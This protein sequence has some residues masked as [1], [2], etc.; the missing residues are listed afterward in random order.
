MSAV[1]SDFTGLD[2][3]IS[4]EYTSKGTEPASFL[5]GF[6]LSKDLNFVDGL[7]FNSSL[8]IGD[9]A[10]VFVVPGET[11]LSIEGGFSLET[12]FGII[13]GPNESEELVLIGSACEGNGL[14]NC[15]PFDPFSFYIEW[16]VGNEETVRN[17]T[18][19]TAEG[20][21][22]ATQELQRVLDNSSLSGNVT[23]TSVGSSSIVLNFDAS[24]SK[25]VLLVEKDC[26][27][28]SDSSLNPTVVKQGEFR[29]PEGTKPAPS[30]SPTNEY[31]FKD[32]EAKKRGYQFVVGSTKIT[33]DIGIEGSAEVGANVGEVIEIGAEID[34]DFGGNLVFSA[35]EYGEYL[36][37]NDW[38]IGITSIRSDFK[39][40]PANYDFVRASATFDGS[41]SVDV[42]VK[43]P[44]DFDV[45]GSFRGG[46]I[47]P[48]T[49]NFLDPSGAIT[50]NTTNGTAGLRRLAIN[51]SSKPMTLF[52]RL[53]DDL[54][55]EIDIPNIGD[56][57]NLSFADVVRLLAQALEFLVGPGEE[58]TPESCTGGLLSKEFFGEN[59]FLYKIPVVGVSACDSAGFLKV[60][61]DAVNSLIEETEQSEGETSTVTFSSLERKLESLLQDGVG[62]SPDASIVSTSDD[63]RSTLEVTITLEW[64]FEEAKSL[65]IDLAAI[66]DGLGFDPND[67]IAN[68]AKSLVAFDGEALTAIAGGLSVTVGVGLEYHKP[69]KDIRPYIQG[70]TG[71]KLTFAALADLSFSATIGPLSATVYTKTVVDNYDDLLTVKIGLEDSLNYYLRD[72]NDTWPIDREGFVGVDGIAKLVDELDVTI[73]GRV[74]GSIEADFGIVPA[75]ASLQI[76]ISDINNVLQKKPNAISVVYEVD[77]DVSVSIPSIVDILLADP[78]AIVDAVDGAFREAEEKAMGKRGIVT[79]SNLPFV[80]DAVAKKLEAGKSENFLAKARRLIVGEMRTILD[81]YEEEEG[82]V[83]TVADI[84]AIELGNLLGPE[85]ANILKPDL[86]NLTYYRHTDTDTG[87]TRQEVPDSEDIQSIKSEIGSL[88]WTI[89]FGKGGPLRDCRCLLCSYIS[90]L[91]A[92][93]YVCTR[94]LISFHFS[95]SYRAYLYHGTS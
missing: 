52:Q 66:L 82:G 21:S 58:D 63:I 91:S 29:C 14:T 32:D 7:S 19:V 41:F 3:E 48:F 25:V 55:L 12:E 62:G 30:A 54:F 50:A 84:L 13:L 39:D 24:I 69:T 15:A 23:V 6:G 79:R 60:F 81:S 89:N 31:G 27:N 93:V 1:L 76:D 10:D 4:A 67:P 92:H 94:S 51:D 34:A 28:I 53:K 5:I 64:S 65:E 18:F 87:K 74:S 20:K 22:N 71:L 49:I 38:L 68:F 75:S 44:F 36:S 88:M 77:F 90:A 37:F 8:S 61:V 59:I 70:V 9:L 85:G 11:P 56:I 95:A 72:K 42:R 83:D 73:A 80:G 78:N 2:I 47:E 86:V 40:D 43:E 17:A 33:A 57:R 35:N 16:V 46:F 26:V 45:P